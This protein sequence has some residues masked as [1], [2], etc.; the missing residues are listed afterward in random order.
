MTQSPKQNSP[1]I[2]L[3]SVTKPLKTPQFVM[4]P[5]DEK[6]AELDFEALMSCR[7]RLREELQWSSWPPEDFTLEMNRADLRRHHD[8]FIRGEAF[9][10]T[11]LRR[12]RAR[13]LGCIYIERCA[14][15]EGAQLAF[16]VID[17]AIDIE[18]VLVTEVLQWVHRAWSIDRVLIPL[19]EANTRG[20]ALARKCGFT[21][22]DSV[23][24]SPLSNHRCFLSESGSGE[25]VTRAQ[26]N[27]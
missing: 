12:D 20:I 9:A 19:R 26:Y 4:E 22:W 24:D 10:Y 5:L 14:E 1:W 17:D 25:V 16:W 8:E 2:P 6:H 7:V 13:C 27:R 21:A 11:V 3:A 15:I 23:K 18:A